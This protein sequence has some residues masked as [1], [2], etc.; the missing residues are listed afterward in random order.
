MSLVTIGWSKPSADLAHVPMLDGYRTGVT[1]QYILV[2]DVDLEGAAG[3]EVAEAV[4]TATNHPE[5]D[6]LAGT[7]AGRLLAAIQ[8]TG[9]RGREA[10]WS[11]SVGDTVCVGG[12]VYACAT[13]GFDLVHSA[14]MGEVTP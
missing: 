7:L 6:R 10:H 14:P 12:D 4:F 2:V 5:P 9:Y 1:D 13:L 3:P 8:A 11:L